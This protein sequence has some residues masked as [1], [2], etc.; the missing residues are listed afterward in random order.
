[1]NNFKTLVT[2]LILSSATIIAL[3]GNRAEV[4]IPG[5]DL[6]KIPYV[7]APG[8]KEGVDYIPKT[9]IFSIKPAYRQ[10]CKANSIDN[11][12][13][14]TDFLRVIG[15]TNV[16]KIYP[17]HEAPKRLRNELGQ[18]YADL[19]LIYSCK[20]TGDI[21]IEKVMSQM[22]S[23]G[24]CEYVEPWIIPHVH[25]VLTPND[26]SWSGSQY[27]LK[28][29][30][31]GS[32]NTVTAWSTTTGLA[33]IIIGSVDTGTEPNHPDL[34]ANMVPGYDVAMNDADPTWEGTANGS[35][36]HGV[37]TSGDACATTNN[38]IGVAS[39]GYT[40][41]FM[42]V[43][44]A[45]ATG[46]L[47]AAYQG[48]VY[49]ADHGC[50][51]ISMS[52]GSSGGAGSYGQTVMNYAAINKNCLLLASAGNGA[53]EEIIY[54][55]S[56]DNVYRV[57]SSTSTD[58]KSGFSSYGYDVDYSA[59]G[60]QI[61][62]TSS[63]GGY[64]AVDGTSMACPVS[65]GAAGLIQSKFNYA[66]AF[67]IGERMKQTCDPMTGSQFTSGKMGKGR[68]NVGTAVSSA[69]AE[70]IKMTPITV[71]DG[72]D[73]AFMPAE[74]L[75]ISGI[76]I[77]YLDPST[78]AATA[79]L[80]IVSVSAGTAPTIIS[81]STYNIGVVASLGTTNNNSSPFK[82][83]ISP[84]AP[85]NQTIKFKV[86]IVDGAFSGDQ[87]FDVVVNVDFINITINDVYTTMTSTGRIGYSLDSQAQGLG[88][89]YQ[90]P[91]ANSILYEM[92]LMI[93]TSST[94][95]SDMFRDTAVGNTDFK[96]TVRATMV[97]PSSKSDFD[98]DGQFND[99]RSISPLPVTVHQSAHA[100]NTAPY[101]K[102]VILNY[103]IKNTGTSTL[104]GVRVGIVADWDIINSGAKNKAG[105]DST[106]RMGYCYDVSVPNSIYSATKL[107][108]SGKT[109]NYI[110]DNTKGGGGAIDVSDNFS[111]SE[112]YQAMSTS[113]NADGYTAAGGDVMNCVS[114]G[115]FSINAGDSITVAF[116]LIGGDNLLDLQLSACN[117]QSKY[118]NTPCLVG[119]KNINADNFSIV[120]YPNPANTIINFD[121]NLVENK[122]A[123]L[124]VMNYLG[125]IV[126]SYE[127]ISPG[128]NTISMDVSK[129]STGSYFYQLKAG[130]S[131]VTKK[132]TV[133]R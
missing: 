62:S 14:V 38:G 94:K 79:T 101:R 23:L 115:P 132:F 99:S 133:I 75:S 92:S 67:Q 5:Q 95:V 93:G 13:A 10:N 124:Y 77:N 102:F 121:Y 117:A 71:T 7:M 98:V 33:S 65:A 107:L 70:S 73:D 81:A 74:T 53:T 36:D 122:N 96:S 58:T 112:K 42:P 110:I 100:W 88:F 56:Y 84:T 8:L 108:S 105:F 86:H 43:K 17:T 32:I 39:P 59:P 6:S 111:T 50:N 131:V 91:T 54:P 35:N 4:I 45:D 103:V 68:I 28:G 20:Y 47:V 22:T 49:A 78:T 21:K 40:C 12:V 76:F 64:Q 9:I 30:V 120:S 72:N 66:N 126:S 52:W 18:K 1:M 129:L 85:L 31:K 104:S 48:V 46:A 89:I 113:R 119:V 51:I 61:Y 114:T 69:T 125:E 27:H 41:K 29:A 44:I 83:A 2:T 57:A 11:L 37:Y 128:K 116:A 34:K 26:P 123:N 15:A 87:F 24:Y 55:S 60:T 82:V 16:A 63:G 130:E 106:N 127:N 118:D 19:S 3:A 90:L 25:I 80:S 109:N 97:T